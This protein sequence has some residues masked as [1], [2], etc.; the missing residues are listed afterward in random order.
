MS[1]WAVMRPAARSVSPSLNFSRTSA[2]APEV[3]K[4]RPNGSTP[5]ARSAF[6]F[7]RRCAISSFS[8]SMRQECLGWRGVGL[9]RLLEDRQSTSCPATFS[10]MALDLPKTSSKRDGP[11]VKQFSVFLANKVGAMHDVLKLL[12]AHEYHAIA[13]SVSES[14]DS[15]I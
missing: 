5:R 12:N 15:A 13:M 6:N 3:S 1:R 8:G 9:K 11:L 14:T 10:E 2:I 7:S 4:A